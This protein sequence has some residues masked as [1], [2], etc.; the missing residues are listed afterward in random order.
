MAR[1]LYCSFDPEL[2]QPMDLE[3][4]WDLGYMGTYSDDRQPVLDRLL[5]AS[6][7]RWRSGRFVV[8][9]PQYPKDLRWPRNVKRIQHLE[10]ARHAEFYNTQRFTLNV[11]RADMVTAGWSPSVR[12]FEAAACATPIL[13]DSWP[14]LE[15]FFTLGEEIL[16][17]R[18]AGDV[19][20]YL[21][22]IPERERRALGQRARRRV[23]AQHTAAHR[24]EELEGYALSLLSRGVAA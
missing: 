9:G 10:P 17:V 11:T 15:S 5:T 13:S 6:A 4:R 21:R 19:L 1:P 7:Q 12:L 3:P 8:A 20:Q 2:Y 22:D 16:P 23:L 14:G 18:N 24:A